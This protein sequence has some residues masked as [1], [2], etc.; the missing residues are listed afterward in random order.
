MYK[1]NGCVSL[2]VQAS[3][4]CVRT[5]ARSPPRHPT[6]CCE[7]ETADYQ[8]KDPMV[9]K[10]QKNYVKYGNLHVLKS[11]TEYSSEVSTWIYS[12]RLLKT[13]LATVIALEKFLLPGSS[14]ISFPE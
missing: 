3:S 14:M 5:R 9:K 11:S 7:P 4:S 1:Y 13:C 2:P 8:C 6:I 10:T 12:V